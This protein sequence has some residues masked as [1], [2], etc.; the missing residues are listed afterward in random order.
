LRAQ[1]VGEPQD[2][3][4]MIDQAVAAVPGNKATKDAFRAELVKANLATHTKMIA[5]ATNGQGRI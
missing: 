5:T 4:D 3:I 2:T 1:G